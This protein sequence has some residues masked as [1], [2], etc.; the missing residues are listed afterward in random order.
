MSPQ[1]DEVMHTCSDK[2]YCPVATEKDL[3]SYL[4]RQQVKN[5]MQEW[6]TSY[7]L[8][9]HALHNGHQ[10]MGQAFMN[11]LPEEQYELL[12]GTLIDPFYKDD[13]K[14]VLTALDYL[15]FKD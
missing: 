15:V 7:V 13:I 8:Y 2:G 3:R 4:I 11:A 9:S 6:T 12:T 5:M 10:R 14:S 1:Y